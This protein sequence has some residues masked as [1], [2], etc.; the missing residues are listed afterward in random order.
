MRVSFCSWRQFED[1]ARQLVPGQRQLLEHLDPGG[2]GA[3][4][5]L[6]ALAAEVQLVEQ[7]LAQLLGRAQVEAA[8][9]ELVGLGLE[10]G[11]ALGELGRELAQAVR[12]D[13]DAVAF[14][15]GH[16]RH[17]GPVQRLVDGEHVLAEQLRAQ[18]LPQPQR[19][20]G[21][22][23]GVGRGLVD[24]HLGKADLR[25][26]LAADGARRGCGRGQVALRQLVHAVAV[27]GAVQ[28]V[29][30]QHGVVDRA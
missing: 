11:H 5:G 28:H 27:A 25:R 15:L 13:L 2:E 29:G 14:H 16:D 4:L 20:L 3:G 17:D 7:D 26:P 10:A 8:A 30:D 21:V 24:R 19:H 23:G 6:A 1:H 9:G 22:L 12:V 18:R